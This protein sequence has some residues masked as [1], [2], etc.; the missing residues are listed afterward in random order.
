MKTSYQ[1]TVSRP[2]IAWQSALFEGNWYWFWGKNCEDVKKWKTDK[3][4]IA[5]QIPSCSPPPC[6]ALQKTETFSSVKQF[7]LFSFKIQSHDFR[8]QTTRFQITRY[9]RETFLFCDLLNKCV[10]TKYFM[11]WDLAVIL[12]T[13]A[14]WHCKS[15]VIRNNTRTSRF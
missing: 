13:T 12:W 10:S 7:V 14:T 3:V 9:K 1:I 8:N 6:L 4:S 5:C 11:Q 2:L 15:T